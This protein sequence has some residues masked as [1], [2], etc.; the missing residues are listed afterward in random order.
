MSQLTLDPFLPGGWMEKWIRFFED[1]SPDVARKRLNELK[2]LGSIVLNTIGKVYIN[3]RP[4]HFGNGMLGL[5]GETGSAKS[6]V[7]EIPSLLL[8]TIIH[9]SPQSVAEKIEE[10]K[11]GIYVVYEI[12]EILKIAQRK[13]YMS[14]W[15]NMIALKLYNLEE[16]SVGRVE[17]GKKVERTVYIP[18][19]QYYVSALFLGTYDDFSGIFS[20]WP[21][22]KR[23]IL[24]LNFG[25]T[26]PFAA[27]PIT[28]EGAKALAELRRTSAA[29]SKWAF[30]VHL[31]WNYETKI[32]SYVQ[33]KV[34][35]RTGDPAVAR[36]AAEYWVKLMAAYLVDEAASKLAEIGEPVDMSIQFPH[37]RHTIISLNKLLE[38]PS[39]PN[40]VLYR[41]STDISNFFSCYPD[42]LEFL[43]TIGVRGVDIVVGGVAIPPVDTGV[44]TGGD[45]GTLIAD[46]LIDT[47]STSWGQVPDMAA[48]PREERFFKILEKVRNKVEAAGKIRLRKLARSFPSKTATY[49]E[50][51]R[52]VWELDRR[53]EA[54]LWPRTWRKGSH[55]P[56]YVVSSSYMC[57]LNCKHLAFDHE[58]KTYNC[59]KGHDLVGEL[60]MDLTKA[61]KDFEP[62]GGEE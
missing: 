43:K 34:Y 45:V 58:E 13:G 19:K 61:C 39:L 40:H 50:V 1:Y 9:G 41:E 53:G 31:D 24:F 25:K 23:R 57:C 6:W 27:W 2:I 33:R 30:L 59:L 46:M 14:E 11:W 44:P 16:I 35:E 18:P 5:I 49:G 4:I 12:G 42:V 51:V 7:A 62:R 17:K 60:G 52:A 56:V 10:K 15:G 37:S 38:N 28:A 48:S 47:V 8:P 26:L 32:G 22:L 54:R 3:P 36:M 20:L 21:A 29:L 55:T